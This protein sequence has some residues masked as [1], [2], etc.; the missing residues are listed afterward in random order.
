M[1][2]RA[3]KS[4]GSESVST[5]AAATTLKF[6]VSRREEGE[7]LGL[8]A[9]NELD[10]ITIFQVRR[11]AVK[12]ILSKSFRVDGVGS[13]TTKSDSTS[14]LLSHF[15]LNSSS[16]PVIDYFVAQLLNFVVAGSKLLRAAC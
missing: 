1:T 11:Q 3:S 8:E 4:S 14:R 5:S 16:V 10:A 2:M 7:A 9:P 12:T 15:W 13:A 6:A